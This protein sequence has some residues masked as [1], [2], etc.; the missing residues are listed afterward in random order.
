MNEEIMENVEMNDDC[1]I[2]DIPERSEVPETTSSDG[3][4]GLAVL[5][6]AGIA[7]AGFAAFKIGKKAL[8]KYKANKKRK[9]EKAAEEID[10]DKVGD[11]TKI[12][13]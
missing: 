6:G 1:E 8:A 5:I 4:S 9:L 12:D 13:E 3:N 2:I 7:A 11:E 10:M